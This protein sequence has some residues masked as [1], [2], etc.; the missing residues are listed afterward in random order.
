MINLFKGYIATLDKYFFFYVQNKK[1]ECD[2][3]KCSLEYQPMKF[4]L[5]KHVNKKRDGEWKALSEE[6]KQIVALRSSL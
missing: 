1:D 3:G 4:A 5:N 2:E 6:E